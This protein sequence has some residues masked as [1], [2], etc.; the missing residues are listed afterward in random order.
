M[1]M[2]SFEEEAFSW[3]LIGFDNVGDLGIWVFYLI[4]TWSIQVVMN[5]SGIFSSGPALLQL[6][7]GHLF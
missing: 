2:R 5:C 3:W 6:F 4:P 7:P 1:V